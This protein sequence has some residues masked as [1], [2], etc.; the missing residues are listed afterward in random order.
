MM[1]M[2]TQPPLPPPPVMG[3]IPTAPVPNPPPLVAAASNV[4]LLRNVPSFLQSFAQLKDWLVPCGAARKI[5]VVKDTNMALVTMMH[6][7]GALKLVCAV[8][9]LSEL[10]KDSPEIAKLQ[11]QLVPASPDIP[12]PPPELDENITKNVGEDLWKLWGT[13]KEAVSKEGEGGTKD[14]TATTATSTATEQTTTT[15][16]TTALDSSKVAA[17][18]GGA[19]DEDADPLNA[20]AVLELVKKFRSQLLQN[21]AQQRAERKRVVAEKIQEMLPLV[22][23]RMERMPPGGLPPPLPPPPGGLPPP[24]P[25]VGGVLPPPIPPGSLPPPPGSLPPPPVPLTGVPPIAPPL[26]PPPPAGAIPPPP[27]PT[28]PTPLSVDEPPTKRAKL[29]HET[30]VDTNFVILPESLHGTLRAFIASQIKELL[31]EEEATLI[32]FIFKHVVEGKSYAALQEELAVVLE[33]DAPAFV[34]TLKQKV[35]SGME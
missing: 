10:Y 31:G 17:A 22:K 35:L 23:E 15:T 27:P 28:E 24:I 20:P 18:A 5:L 33:E 16:T 34:E 29:T 11:A 32:D 25:P 2:A 30:A 3:A 13:I 6:G 19:Y 14:T 1:T 21:Q 9:Y 4:V 8:Q 26:P 7:D 12:M